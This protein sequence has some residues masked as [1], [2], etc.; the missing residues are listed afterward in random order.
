MTDADSFRQKT[1]YKYDHGNCI[2][3]VSDTAKRYQVARVI[4]KYNEYGDLLDETSYDLD[5]SLH[6]QKSLKYEA[7]DKSGN[8]LRETTHWKGLRPTLTE[9][10][11]EYY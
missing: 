1:V 6:S 11:I 10:V 5:G 3:E 9:R 4:R 7:Y 2:S 8:W